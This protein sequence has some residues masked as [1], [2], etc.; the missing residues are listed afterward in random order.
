MLQDLSILT[1]SYLFD[2]SESEKILNC[3]L[4][5][6]GRWPIFGKVVFVYEGGARKI[7]ISQSDTFISGGGGKADE[8][9]KRIEEIKFLISK[10]TNPPTLMILKVYN[11]NSNIAIIAI[12]SPE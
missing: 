5:D 8:I 1:G 12:G 11:L 2:E 9:N 7:K 4:N 10:T 6:L 3:E